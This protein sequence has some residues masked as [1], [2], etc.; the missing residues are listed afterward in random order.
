MTAYAHRVLVYSSSVVKYSN[1]IVHFKLL[2]ILYLN[3]F[4]LVT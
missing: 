1:S 3:N 2:E 4:F